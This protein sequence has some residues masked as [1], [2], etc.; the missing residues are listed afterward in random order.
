VKLKTYKAVSRR[1]KQAD[2]A[3]RKA[4]ARRPQSRPGAGRR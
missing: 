4:M 2:K 1:A 3:R